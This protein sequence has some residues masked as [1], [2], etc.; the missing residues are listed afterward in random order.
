MSSSGRLNKLPSDANAIAGFSDATFEHIA[1]S[2]L[3][4]DLFDI[5][6][7]ALVGKAGVPS[8]HEEPTRFGKRSDDVLGNSV[9]KVF[10]FGITAHVLKC[11][12]C[13]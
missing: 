3:A 13:D 10:L 8:Y 11:K 6:S 4:A 2:K 9:G 5:D 7:V 1:H 12:N